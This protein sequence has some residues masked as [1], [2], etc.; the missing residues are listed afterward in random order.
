MYAAIMI[1]SDFTHGD[2]LAVS[3]F[4]A[5]IVFGLLFNAFQDTV[6]TVIHDIPSRVLK[7]R[8]AASALRSDALVQK[9]YGNSYHF[10]VTVCRMAI[11]YIFLSFFFFA[12]LILVAEAYL[13]LRFGLLFDTHLRQNHPAIIVYMRI[14]LFQW[15]GMS[16]FFYIAW[17]QRFLDDL[18]RHERQISMARNTR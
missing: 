2:G 12:A 10:L 17:F 15:F 9:C 11:R 13:Y 18:S 3:L 6:R 16:I 14:L 1:S 5:S 8:L 4:I 7:E